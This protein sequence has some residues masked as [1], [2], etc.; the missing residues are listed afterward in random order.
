M[1]GLNNFFGLIEFC[2]KRLAKGNFFRG[3]FHKRTK[4]V[5]RRNLVTSRGSS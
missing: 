1:I 5:K 2:Y 3:T 4:G